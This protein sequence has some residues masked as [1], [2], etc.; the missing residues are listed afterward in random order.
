[1]LLEDFISARSS[2]EK[3]SGIFKDDISCFYF[4]SGVYDGLIKNIVGDNKG[5]DL[6]IFRMLLEHKS[7]MLKRFDVL[8]EAGVCID[9]SIKNEY[10]EIKIDNSV[11]AHT[12]G[13]AAMKCE[14]VVGMAAKNVKDGFVKI[15]K[16][17]NFIN[18][19]KLNIKDNLLEIELHVIVEYGTNITKAA[20]GII[21]A[22]KYS[23]NDILGIDTENIKVFVEGIKVNN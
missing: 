5:L 18:G 20:N 10:G 1:M 7:C 15:L 19:I 6:R 4:G 22:V 14:G 9:D 8:G 16:G 17:E 3:P 12:A 21:G 23:V 11:I 2:F 13:I